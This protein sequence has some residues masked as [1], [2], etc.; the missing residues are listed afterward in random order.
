MDCGD[1]GSLYRWC[2]CM[3]Q[4]QEKEIRRFVGSK[5]AE[6]MGRQTAA[7]L[8]YRTGRRF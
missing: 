1:T 7:L 5:S 8:T 2:A 6:G 3:A 4:Y